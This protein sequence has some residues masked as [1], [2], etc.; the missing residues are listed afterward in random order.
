MP[1]VKQRAS[2]RRGGRLIINSDAPIQRLEIT[3]KKTGKTKTVWI[4]R[5]KGENKIFANESEARAF[6]RLPT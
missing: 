3:N 6:A 5:F 2:L 4:A 1:S